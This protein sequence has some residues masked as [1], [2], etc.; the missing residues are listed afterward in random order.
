[1][2][3]PEYLEGLLP[4]LVVGGCVHQEHDKQEEVTSDAAR[5]SVVYLLSG[6]LADFCSI[7]GRLTFYL[8][9]GSTLTS[10]LNIDKIDIVSGSMND[11]PE[12]HRIRHLPVEPNVFIG[13]E[14]PGEFRANDT[15]N[16]A[17]H[18]KKDETAIVR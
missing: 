2:R 1:M 16:V 4:Y 3:V 12:C 10:S 9:V 15:D 17:Q 5:F 7:M 11:S 18:G 14:E 8:R 6:L 13:R